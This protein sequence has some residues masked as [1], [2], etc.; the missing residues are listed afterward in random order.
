MSK[1]KC[2]VS[3]CGQGS[4]RKSLYYYPSSANRRMPLVMCPTRRQFL[5]SYSCLHNLLRYYLSLKLYEGQRYVCTVGKGKGETDICAR[6]RARDLE[7]MWKATEAGGDTSPDPSRVGCRRLTP[8]HR[9]LPHPPTVSAEQELGPLKNAL[10]QVSDK[11][12]I[13]RKRFNGQTIR[14]S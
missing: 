11:E 6:I 1:R 12:W 5:L 8:G 2:S 13:L 14:F 4:A 3:L 9:R 10:S 7:H